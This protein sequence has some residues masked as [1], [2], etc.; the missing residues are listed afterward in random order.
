MARAK[1]KTAMLELP[2]HLDLPAAGPLHEQLLGLRGGALGI[3][4]SGVESL[5]GQCLQVLLSAVATWRAD[6]VA[7]RFER[8]SAGFENGLALLG[9]S[10]ERLGEQEVAR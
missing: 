5:G 10:L 7:L 3:D 8:P 9:L 2:R 1:A 6:A 4:A